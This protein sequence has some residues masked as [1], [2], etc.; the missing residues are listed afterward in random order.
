VKGILCVYRLLRAFT[1]FGTTSVFFLHPACCCLHWIL[2]SKLKIGYWR[3]YSTGNSCLEELDNYHVPEMGENF[4]STL[5]GTTM[6]LL[7]LKSNCVIPLS[8][9]NYKPGDV[10]RLY[11]ETT[12]LKLYQNDTWKDPAHVQEWP[13]GRL[14][15][16]WIYSLS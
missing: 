3:R 13:S 4:P 9:V 8:E 16:V 7:Y 10:I 14:D 15:S 2:Q 1:A 6:S 5:N 12:R 11:I